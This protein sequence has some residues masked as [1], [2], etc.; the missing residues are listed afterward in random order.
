MALAF[1]AYAWKRR[2][3]ANIYGDDL[4]GDEEQEVTEF[5][6]LRAA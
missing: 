2:K 4:W 5:S 6:M 1:A 3:S